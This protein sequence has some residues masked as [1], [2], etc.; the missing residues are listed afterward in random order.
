MSISPKCLTLPFIVSIKQAAK[1][2]LSFNE[3]PS[4]ISN[5]SIDGEALIKQRSIVGI[6]E[7][8]NPPF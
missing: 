1:Q 3:M 4:N 2:E 6:F 7:A 8:S 5:R